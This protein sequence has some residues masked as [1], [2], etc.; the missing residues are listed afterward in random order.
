MSGLAEG[1]CYAMSPAV[2]HNSIVVKLVGSILIRVLV[3]RV[4]TVGYSD[5]RKMSGVKLFFQSSRVVSAYIY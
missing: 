3:H 2:V 4:P 1:D 5:F